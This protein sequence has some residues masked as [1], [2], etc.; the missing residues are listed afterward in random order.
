[1]ILSLS[2]ILKLEEILVFIKTNINYVPYKSM[3][4]NILRRKLAMLFGQGC[5]VF[6]TIK[7]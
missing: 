5:Y 3:T 4:E 2:G 6:N 1:M 7:H